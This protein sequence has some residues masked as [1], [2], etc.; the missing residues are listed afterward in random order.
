M[1]L[2]IFPFDPRSSKICN[3]AIND[4]IMDK[5]NYQDVEFKQSDTFGQKLITNYHQNQYN[6]ITT[7]DKILFGPEVTFNLTDFTFQGDIITNIS[8]VIDLPFD[9]AELQNEYI[10]NLGTN[11]IEYVYITINDQT[12]LTTYGSY[13]YIHPFL[14]Y[15]NPNDQS[16]I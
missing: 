7:N 12:L 2:N 9:S 16:T 5:K 3:M 11:L 1:Y 8:V 13:I 6:I 10:Q 15:P 4:N 14:F